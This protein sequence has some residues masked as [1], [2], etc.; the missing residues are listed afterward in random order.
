[1]NTAELLKA[2]PSRRIKPVDGMAVTAD[3][4]EEAHDYHRGQLRYHNLLAHGLGIVTG[5][6]VVASDPPDSAVYVSPGVGIDAN[7]RE[8]MVA[9]PLSFDLGA[10]QG[11]LYLVLT[12]GEGQPRSEGG[13]DDGVMYIQEQFAL[14]AVGSLSNTAGIE[15]A[16]IKRSGRSTP[17]VN[18][19]DT[20]HPAANEIDFRFRKSVGASTSAVATV[21]VSYL[22]GL[23]DQ[24]HGRGADYLARMISRSDQK[25]VWIDDDAPLNADLL[26]YTLV[27]LVGHTAFQLSPDE[28]NAIYAYLQGGG[29]LLYESC[30]HDASDDPKAD[31]AFLDLLSSLGQ[32]I[33]DLPLNH[34]LLVEPNLFPAPPAGFDASG[35]IR[36]GGGVIVSTFDYGCIWQ[37]EKRG[38]AASRE[39]IRSAH[40][41][42]ENIVTYARARR[43]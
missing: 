35:K 40:E 5:L 32:K 34:P 10:A 9:Q 30:R 26:S 3:V 6:E 42:G 8:I 4:W 15:L 41:W 1:V 36:I 21:A 43:T 20:A 38:G 22:G 39:E 14:E 19:K 13:Q 2:Y 7:G 27:Y 25:R 11:I 23:K 31:A 17:I 24:R 28:M 33:D 16:R 37:G 18:A 12:H 29:T